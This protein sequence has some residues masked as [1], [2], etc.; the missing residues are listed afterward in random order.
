MVCLH[1][2]AT[3]ANITPEN[4][5]FL[6]WHVSIPYVFRLPLNS[7]PIRFDSHSRIRVKKITYRFLQ[8]SSIAY[9]IIAQ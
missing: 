8:K 7:L 1:L 4:G 5:V 6:T 9:N 3:P 2:D